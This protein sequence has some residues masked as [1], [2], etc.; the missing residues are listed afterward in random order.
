MTRYVADPI[1]QPGDITGINN[2][3]QLIQESITTMLS[4]M[5]DSPN[6]MVSNLDM[7]GNDIINQGNPFILDGFNW[8]GPWVTGTVYA[9][10]DAVFN[11]SSAYYCAL[12]N[13][14]SG[15]F[16][17]DL[18]AGKWNIIVLGTKF[19]GEWVG[20]GTAYFRGDVVVVSPDAF[21]YCLKDHLSTVFATD[22]GAG[23]WEIYNATLGTMAIQNANA[24]AITGGT[25]TDTDLTGSTTS[26]PTTSL[27]VA[28]K[29]YVDNS[30]ATAITNAGY[31][32]EIRFSIGTFPAGWLAMNDGTVGN[33][34]SGATYANANLANLF[35][36]LWAYP[37]Q[38]IPMFTSAGVAQARGSSAAA[39]FT[40]EMQL[41]MPLTVGRALCNAGTMSQLN[42]I[43][44]A[45]GNVLTVPTTLSLY[46]GTPCQVINA[47]GALPAPLAP[48][49]P[50]YIVNLSGTT[51]SLATS[52]ANVNAGIVITL[53]T[54][55]SGT[56]T[57]QVN[58]SGLTTVP[59]Q[60][61][62]EPLHQD[63]TNEL[64][65]HMHTISTN[66][67]SADATPTY[68][69]S[70][71]NTTGAG[72]KATTPTGGNQPHNNMQPSS[73]LPAYIHI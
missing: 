56:N 41:M 21:Y 1:T 3:F 34:A 40:A 53:T 5:A 64:A 55:G 25:I 50:Y 47:G 22:L 15:A 45:A 70:S 61:L 10:G 28:N 4:R 46:N 18:N 12:A 44:T 30:I 33:A 26:D 7:N 17:T 59:T 63:I 60:Y 72:T 73:F 54:T 37:V 43:F 49:T 66:N 20:P 8:R 51:V 19:Q 67:A 62:G 2:N 14:A 27:E 52:P 36:V 71:D 11:D 6:Y 58:Y 48:A 69:N 57:I 65:A 39:D 23:D 16:F 35:A 42:L 9:V 31:P 13:T 68:Q 29:E 32:G 24:V 38:W